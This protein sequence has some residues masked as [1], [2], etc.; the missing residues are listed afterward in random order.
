MIFPNFKKIPNSA[1]NYFKDYKH[2]N[3]HLAWTVHRYFSC[4]IC[5]SKLTVFIELCSWKIFFLLRTNTVRWQIPE[6]I[7]ATSWVYSLLYTLSF[8]K[9]IKLN[10][11]PIYSHHNATKLICYFHNVRILFWTLDG[12]AHCICR[13]ILTVLLTVG[14]MNLCQVQV[15]S[16]NHVG[17][18]LSIHCSCS[19]QGIQLFTGLD[20]NYFLSDSRQDKEYFDLRSWFID[21]LRTRIVL[22][23]L[24][25][26]WPAESYKNALHEVQLR[27]SSLLMN[28][29]CGAV[30][31]QHGRWCTLYVS[32]SYSFL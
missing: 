19:I 13:Q 28:L 15:T 18:M 9:D 26:F 6:H 7:F 10:S 31:H 21:E 29:M 5:S 22:L 12:H 25:W 4:I 2:S 17:Q 14:G 3:L 1:K 11:H 20:H 16:V 23:M 30:S 27:T 24:V 32:M 8:G